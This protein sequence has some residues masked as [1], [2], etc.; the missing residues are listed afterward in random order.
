MAMSMF[1]LPLA[2]VLASGEELAGSSRFLRV[3][4]HIVNS[5]L[6]KPDVVSNVAMAKDSTAAKSA[7][8]FQGWYNTHAT[9]RG[10]WKWNNALDAYQRHMGPMADTPLKLV[11]VG[12]QSGG[13]IQMWQA[14]LGAQ[15]HVYGLDINAGVNKFKD[16]TTTITIGD[17]ADV[18]MWG[19]F[20]A[21][22]VMAPID[23]LID[24]GGHESHQMLVTLMQTFGHLTPGG[25]I[26]IEDIHGPSYVESFFVPSAR[27][28]GQMSAV[29]QLASVHVYP[30]VLLA[31]K[32][33][34]D[35]RA[36]LA[37]GGT[38]TTVYDFAAL[39]ASLDQHRG[40]H[41]ILENAGWG[42]FLT[43]QGL[44][45]FF[46]LFGNLHD[47]TWWDQPT[48][49]RT[50]AAAV[51]TV[52]VINADIQNQITGI[53]VFPNRLVVEVAAGPVTIQAVRKG[54]EW[55]PYGF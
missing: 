23:V 1:L 14:V 16:A 31:T 13:S 4:P 43:E 54:T 10:I 12:V 46:R 21:S 34:N 18:Q 24:D 2:A 52:T 20:F 26:A 42:P 53:H 44:T 51:C 7:F 47:S 55:L 40:G 3:S 37:F 41:V 30:F 11:E 28:L 32:A 33:G 39:W 6:P 45:N 29:G 50:T 8:T 25:V 19:N 22:T 17:Q 9:G 5:T 36:P 27:F 15:C 38:T 49:C 35:A 48:G